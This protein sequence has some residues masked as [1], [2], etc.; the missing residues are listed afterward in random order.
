MENPSRLLALAT[1]A[2]AL[3]GGIWL[4]SRDSGVA[5]SVPTLPA[6]S[7]PLE[8]VEVAELVEP[9]V[10]SQEA[11]KAPETARHE[12]PE[13][14]SVEKQLVVPDDAIWVE[15]RVI[16][17]PMTPL[18]ETVKVIA[19]GRPFPG[20]DKQRKHSVEVDRSG[21]FRVAFAPGTKTGWIRLDAHYL[22][23]EQT[24]KLNSKEL[25]DEVL[26]EPKV[27]ARLLVNVILPPGETVEHLEEVNVHGYVSEPSSTAI[28]PTAGTQQ[29][30]GVFE[31]P[32]LRPGKRMSVGTVSERYCDEDKELSS[33]QAGETRALELTLTA[34]V[35]LAGLITN[36][37]NE[38]LGG[39]LVVCESTRST[40]TNG[41]STNY[42]QAKADD[43]GRFEMLGIE[44]GEISLHVT[45]DGLDGE[46]L[47][48]GLLQDGEVREDLLVRLGQGRVI[49]GIVR[50]PDGSPAV[51]A[52][53]T[54]KQDP[55]DDEDDGFFTGNR[56][57]TS[58]RT[59]DE[60]RF[61]VAGLG[62][63]TCEVSAGAKPE[64]KEE[65]GLSLL[66]R[67]RAR[68][69]S[70]KSPEW[71]ASLADIAPGSINL[72][73]TLQSGGS[74]SG[75]VLDDTGKPLERFTV[76]VRKAGTGGAYGADRSPGSSVTNTFKTADG[77]FVLEGV[78][79]G[80][81]VAEV[82]AKG[83]TKAGSKAV[84]VPQTG[85]LALVANRNAL[86]T[87]VVV[88]PGGR[89]IEG[90]QVTADENH[91]RVWSTTFGD[92]EAQSD[93]EGEFELNL[94]PG[95]YAL[96]AE[97]GGFGESVETPV[98][99][100]AGTHQ[101]GLVVRLRRAG[102]LL[103]VLDS[104]AGRQAGRRVSLNMSDGR[105]WESTTTDDKGGFEFRDLTPGN[106]EV[107][108]EEE[109]DGQF[110]QGVTTSVR[111]YNDLTRVP[112]ITF[113]LSE[114]EVRN[115]VLGATTVD[116]IRVSGRVT[117]GGEPVGDVGLTWKA[118]SN[119]EEFRCKTDAEGR[120]ELE[121][122]GAG[123]YSVSL[124]RGWQR[125]DAFQ[126]ELPQGS[127]LFEYDMQLPLA[128]VSG[129]LIGPDGNPMGK[130]PVRLSS[131]VPHA[132]E[133]YSAASDEDGNFLFEFVSPGTYTLAA[134]DM[135][136]SWME[137]DARFGRTVLRDLLVT[138]SGLDNLELRLP[139]PSTIEGTISLPDGSIAESC[140]ISITD[141]AGRE[142]GDVSGTWTDD[143][144]HYSLRGL[145]SG[146][147]LITARSR[148]GSS[149]KHEV[150]LTSGSTYN[151]DLVL[152][153][154]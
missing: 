1:V 39:A 72:N 47:D 149:E 103:G 11:P 136:M 51:K 91:L 55:D 75:I 129:R 2:L 86:V 12:V 126:T 20:T 56:G 28:T 45:H 52:R 115:V 114:G 127:K 146:T 31:L 147:F 8:D 58:V 43:E 21:A 154:N 78:Q 135:Y 119:Y 89:P 109:D 111:D 24:L 93:E 13:R 37:A 64:R 26:L 62:A 123:V 96:H 120:Y 44:P 118:L 82:V 139:E 38:A 90:A 9:V 81:W 112:S 54:V 5:E 153:L 50:W 57:T 25:P 152:V 76:T 69:G 128:R 116:T 95:K 99:L 19:R 4:I 104:S 125:G 46:K 77:R 97:L 142:L 87:G 80:A 27:G 67:R 70:R 65:E 83:H 30:D 22:Y 18:D 94:A 102:K 59:N 92:G 34:G 35:K 60:G 66:E 15:G 106:Y 121:I 140:S 48:F 36:E 63:K 17:P 16:F 148:E 122:R 74:V 33:L 98:T 144:G 14:A 49:K 143:S 151:L 10:I 68:Q 133:E 40:G 132:S 85:D 150:R 105:Y 101:A 71:R 32:A 29:D 88:G 3:T 84:S 141:G 61:V 6:A 100:A 53:V 41:S 110:S 107:S 131:Q 124:G 113:A 79:D 73:L 7:D 117:A 23:L 130:A 145:S 42:G 108:L 137:K 138:D 134:S